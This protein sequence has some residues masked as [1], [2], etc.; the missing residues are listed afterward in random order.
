MSLNKILDFIKNFVG[1]REGTKPVH[2]EVLAE[3]EYR[4]GLLLRVSRES[5]VNRPNTVEVATYAWIPKNKT[6]PF[7]FVFLDS[8]E[9]LHIR[10]LSHRIQIL[11]SDRH[12]S[13]EKVE[14]NIHLSE[15]YWLGSNAQANSVVNKLIFYCHSRDYSSVDWGWEIESCRKQIMGV[16]YT[17]FSQTKAR[18]DGRYSLDKFEMRWSVPSSLSPIVIEKMIEVIEPKKEPPKS[19]VVELLIIGSV[20]IALTLILVRR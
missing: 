8:L 5:I 18:D 17:D 3:Q 14:T 20:L 16:N 2:F 10:S 7:L 1:W 12:L 11:S 13:D 6:K 19:R 9:T 15:S 4:D